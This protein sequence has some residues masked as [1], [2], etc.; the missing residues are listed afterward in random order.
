MYG[1][2]Q[3]VIVKIISVLCNSKEHFGN[4]FL[5]DCDSEMRGVL[6][7]GWSGGQIIGMSGGWW[8]GTWATALLLICR[9]LGVTSPMIFSS[10]QDMMILVVGLRYT[11]KVKHA[12]TFSAYARL[13]VLPLKIILLYWVDYWIL[14]I[15]LFFLLIKSCSNI[16]FFKQITTQS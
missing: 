13:V 9:W 1:G 15:C 6:S 5:C 7:F 16:D 10:V 3:F 11:H 12:Q 2:S 8:W 14:C 4:M